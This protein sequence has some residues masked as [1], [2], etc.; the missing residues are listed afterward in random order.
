MP[1]SFFRKTTS[2]R[3]S[4]PN[5]LEEHYENSSSLLKHWYK[6][7]N[8]CMMSNSVI[9]YIN[10]WCCLCDPLL[11]SEIILKPSK[12]VPSVAHLIFSLYNETENN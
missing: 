8:C 2:L 9:F 4:S 1:I 6:I 11:L 7:P 3:K 5:S 12:S 10:K